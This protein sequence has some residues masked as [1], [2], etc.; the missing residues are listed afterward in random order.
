MYKYRWIKKKQRTKNWK[1]CCLASVFIIVL[2]IVVVLGLI[3]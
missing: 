3:S 2:F 1:V